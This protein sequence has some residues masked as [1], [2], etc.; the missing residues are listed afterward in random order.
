MK[1]ILRSLLILAL[2]AAIGL[3]GR[4]LLFFTI[5]IEGTSMEGTLQSGDVVL[6]VRLNGAPAHGDIVQCTFPNRSGTYVK[7][8]VGLPGDMLEFSGGTL[9]RNGRPTSEPFVSSPTEDLTVSLAMDEYYVLG[10]NR[11]ESYDSRAGDMGCI[12]RQDILSRVVWILWPLDHF[13]PVQ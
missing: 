3:L 8:V 12:S 13:G 10:D 5:R 6:A 11:A 1:R 2:A 9:T 4:Q 7:R